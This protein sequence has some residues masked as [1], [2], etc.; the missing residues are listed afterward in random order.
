MGSTLAKKA[1]PA[2]PLLVFIALLALAYGPRKETYLLNKNVRLVF[3]R[4]LKYKE[5]S[6][7]RGLTYRFQFNLDDYR[8]AVREPRPDQPWREV[9]VYAYEGLSRSETPGLIITIHGGRLAS[10]HFEDQR[11]ILTPFVILYFSPVGHPSLRR[12][13]MF[14]ESGETRVL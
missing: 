4:I 12:G 10:Y 14:R 5:F 9:A 1:W 3:M 2:A 8:V 11:R 13:I 6:L 7:H